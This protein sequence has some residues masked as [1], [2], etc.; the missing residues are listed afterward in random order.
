MA[1]TTGMKPGGYYDTHSESPRPAMDSFL[2]WLLEVMHDYG[3]GRVPLA[4][5]GSAIADR[6]A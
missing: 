3:P 4:H 5:V 6:I 1:S 2:P